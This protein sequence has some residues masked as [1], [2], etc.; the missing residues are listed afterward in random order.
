MQNF[1]IKLFFQKIHQSKI[2]LNL[3]SLELHPYSTFSLQSIKLNQTYNIWRVGKRKEKQMSPII[4]LL[5][6]EKIRGGEF[7][8][9]YGYRTK[10][11]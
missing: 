11:T 1:K 4:K 7:I 5:E 10:I 6:S 9:H 2:Y 8:W 3:S